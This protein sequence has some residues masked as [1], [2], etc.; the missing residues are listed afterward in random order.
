MYINDLR[1]SLSKLPMW[2]CGGEHVINH[3]MYADDI[4]LLSSS[5]KGMERVEEV[6]AC[7]RI[8]ACPHTLIFAAARNIWL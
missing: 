6:R 3:I 5:A 1:R 7:P 2:C 8:E 4:V